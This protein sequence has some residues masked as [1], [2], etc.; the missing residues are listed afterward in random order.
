MKVLS[1]LIAAFRI[2]F[3]LGLLT[4]GIG[5]V[6]GCFLVLQISN[7][8][9]KLPSPLSRII[10]TPQ[11]L[12]Y[13]ADGQVLAALGAR[14]AVSL[15]RVSPDFIK[16]VVA[17]EDHRFFEHHGINKLR[18]IKGLYITLF[19]PGQIQGA[20]T[21]TQQLAKN[22]FFS[23]EKTWQRKFKELL[24]A[25]QIEA[26]ATKEEILE[27]YINQIH[28]GAGAQGVEKAART[29]FGKSARELDLG[30]AALLA[31]LPKSP[32]RYNPF[33]YYDRALARRK[34]V[35]GR[36][37]AAGFITPEEARSAE[38]KQP[39]LHKGRTDARTGSYFLDALIQEL[40]G[41]YG[42]DV[43][44]HGG[45]K[46]YATQDPQ[47]Q[48]MADEAVRDGL[49]R[50]DKLMGLEADAPER[51]Q[52]ALVA[53]DTASGAVKA[54]VGGRDYYASE[55][56]RAVNG[57]RQA[58]SGFK[59]F[60][61]YTA[62]ERLGMHPATLVTD[63][64][65][66]IPVTGAPD[67]RPRNFEKR[68]RGP[69]VLKQALV[70]SVNTIAAQLV[71]RTGPRAVIDTARACGIKSPLDNVYSVALGTSGVTAYEMASAF[72]A[73]AGLGTW[74]APFLFWR[75]EDARGR[76]MFERIVKDQR[77]LDPD[78]AFQ[79]VDMMEG[80]VDNGS[81]RSVRRLGFR[82]PAAG[83]TGTSNDYKDAWFTGFTPSL[84]TSVWT[85]F[86][87]EKTL[88]DK[89]G[90]GITGGRGAAPI[91]TDFMIRAMAGEPER[92]FLKPENL[93]F[94][95]VVVTTGCPPGPGPGMPE[96][97]GADNAGEEAV[98]LITVAVKPGQVKCQKGAGDTDS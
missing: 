26:S 89:R 14:D 75:V 56:N 87:K 53:V 86:D 73:F 41:R 4:I 61:Y 51:P 50:L 68:Y 71:A 15:N 84:S 24:V 3:Y 21:I 95:T 83:K 67:W 55:F 12:V 19:K 22:L 36:M 6:A 34:V 98:K 85:G 64:P 17:T 52:A 1:A 94:D 47:L 45:I 77:V 78:L 82:R 63:R 62:F 5:A 44:F 81:G 43:V 70:S 16:A 38:E 59:P 33:R 25:L 32:S 54:M 28:F 2:F 96:G 10:E 35:L 88:R 31:G 18:I 57:K 60:V 79:V 20:S 8:L 65:V 27:A 30:E 69:L 97:E 39:E 9:P 49:D 93:R 80:V 46:V 91:W 48:A 72:S 58:G 23:F 13:G 66:S 74:H 7:D 92:D 76:V 29:F 42:E 37:A 11:S 90:V 40:S